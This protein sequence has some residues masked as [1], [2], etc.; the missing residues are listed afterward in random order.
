MTQQEAKEI[1]QRIRSEY[2]ALPYPKYLNVKLEDLQKK[3]DLL[4]SLKE[5]LAEDQTFVLLK[6]SIS[7]TIARLSKKGAWSN[8]SERGVNKS[9]P[10]VTK[11]GGKEIEFPFEDVTLFKGLEQ[12]GELLTEPRA[13]REGYLEQLNAFTDEL[14]K[15]CRGMHIDFT[16]MN[17]GEALDVSLSSFLATRSA[18]IK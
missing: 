17:S 4:M 16:R 10:L 9:F 18:S 11:K 2:A 1:F 5:Y 15:M 13:L 12:A 14:K 6:N 3:Y 7:Q 8:V